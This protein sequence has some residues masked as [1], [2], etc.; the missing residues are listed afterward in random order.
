[1]FDGFWSGI[2]GGLFGPA[3]SQWLIRFKYWV[4][5]VVATVTVHV[6]SFIQDCLEYGVTVAFERSINLLSKPAGIFAPIAIGLLAVFV[7]FV[8]SLSKPKK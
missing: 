3:I 7:A 5:F 6:A 2:F 8:G 4:I 1:M